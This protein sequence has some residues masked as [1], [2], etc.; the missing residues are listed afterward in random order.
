MLTRIAMTESGVV[1][2]AD[3]KLTASVEPVVHYNIVV[4][5][6]WTAFEWAVA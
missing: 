6:S 4:T 5:K 2:R 1:V 3:E